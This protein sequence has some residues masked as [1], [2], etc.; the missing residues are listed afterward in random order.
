[1]KQH[2]LVSTRHRDF[3]ILFRQAHCAC[4]WSG[5]EWRCDGL[6]GRAAA[7]AAKREWRVHRDAGNHQQLMADTLKQLFVDEPLVIVPVS[8]R[9]LE[10]AR[11]LASTSIRAVAHGHR[12]PSAYTDFIC[13]WGTMRLVPR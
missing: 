10:N 6:V 3:P 12:Q 11:N 4:G 13:P 5:Q 2:R 1:M 8:E 9:T 7:R